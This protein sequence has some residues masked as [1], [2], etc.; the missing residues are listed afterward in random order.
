MS[1][2]DLKT[3]RLCE[4]VMKKSAQ[5]LKKNQEMTASQPINYET[6]TAFLHS[7]PQTDSHCT[8]LLLLET[9]TLTV[10]QHILLLLYL[11]Q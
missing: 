2:A 8:R 6:D 11:V 4:S 5:E 1:H 7:I 10:I 9:I 3:I